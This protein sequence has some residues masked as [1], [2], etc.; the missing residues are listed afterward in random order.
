MTSFGACLDDGAL[1]AHR[2]RRLNE[3]QLEA[4]EKHLAVCATCRAILAELHV[5]VP[6]SLEAWA[7]TTI[8]PRSPWRRVLSV[9]A[10]AAGVALALFGLPRRDHPL[11]EYQ[12]CGP[13]GGALETRS[14]A[15]K[16]STRFV[17]SSLFRLELTPSSRAAAPLALLVFV[18]GL[19]GKLTRAPNSGVTRG[20]GGTFRYEEEAE[21]LFAGGFGRRSVHVAIIAS[22]PASESVNSPQLGTEREIRGALPSHRWFTV[23]LEYARADQGEGE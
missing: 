7:K 3:A 5:E 15:S 13:L 23:G 4:V 22:E 19:D 18:E 11:P 21:R 2:D 16:P 8:A 10:I 20:E 12:L 9:A 14:E 17:P 6:K 1:V